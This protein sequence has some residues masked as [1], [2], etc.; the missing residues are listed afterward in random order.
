MLTNKRQNTNPERAARVIFT[1]AIA[2]IC[3]EFRQ[4]QYFENDGNKRA[5]SSGVDNVGG[6][7]VPTIR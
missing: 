5:L 2:M 6:T 7:C 1:F 4:V 3:W